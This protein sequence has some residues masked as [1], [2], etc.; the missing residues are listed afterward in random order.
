ML[1]F[2]PPSE[3]AE[4]RWNEPDLQRKASRIS[5]TVVEHAT[6]KTEHGLVLLPGV[7]GFG[8]DEQADEPVVKMAYWI[9]PGLTDFGRLSSRFPSK[10]LMESGVTLL[11]GARGHQGLPPES[12]AEADDGND[13]ADRRAEPADLA[14]AEGQAG[15]EQG[16]SRNRLKDAHS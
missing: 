15:R 3:Q 11:R 1:E 13:E 5:E 16:A 10:T 14:D 7:Q 8:P 9:F 6:I 2:T 4:P 12:D